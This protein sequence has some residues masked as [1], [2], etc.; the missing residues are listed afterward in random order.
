[1]ETCSFV[2]WLTPHHCNIPPT[3][4]PK[5]RIVPLSTA[6]SDPGNIVSET[7][8]AVST[9]NDG[10]VIVRMGGKSVPTTATSIDHYSHGATV[11]CS[12]P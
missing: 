9:L 6:M 7:N 4:R 12:R 3:C 1:M 8:S 5:H 11:C 10:I 2:W